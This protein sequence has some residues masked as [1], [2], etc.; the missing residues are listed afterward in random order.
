VYVSSIG[1]TSFEEGSRV[2]APGTTGRGTIYFQ[3]KSFAEDGESRPGSLEL[4]LV[5]AHLRMTETVAGRSIHRNL[6][7]CK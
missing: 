6:V 5:G 2:T 7:R 4:R 1:W 3:V